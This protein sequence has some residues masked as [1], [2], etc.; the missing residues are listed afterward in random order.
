MRKS[1]WTALALVVL[2]VLAL[3][4][5]V[6]S[7]A[8]P[9]GDEYPVFICPALNTHN[10]HGTWVVG[11]H[12]AYYVN[13]VVRGQETDPAPG[14]QNKVFVKVSEDS[15]AVAKAQI[16]AGFALYKD[17][18]PEA[19]NSD[20]SASATV[21]Y[22]TKTAGNAPNAFVPTQFVVLLGEGIVNWIGPFGNTTGWE[23]FDPATVMPTATAGV[24]EVTNLRLMKMGA[25]NSM[26]TITS[27]IPLAAGV[28][29]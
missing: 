11:A 16:P 6:A 4:P 5:G 25:A 15:R 22:D 20:G 9:S 14:V 3:L 23:E 17:V 1:R 8:P 19:F 10:P 2:A 18:F 29:W 12:G 27:P 13:I 21:G 26:V 28:F 24:Y 7:A